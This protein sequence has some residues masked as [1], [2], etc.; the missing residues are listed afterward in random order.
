MEALL[1]A[2]A[3]LAQRDMAA[4]PALA[5][6]RSEMG[7]LHRDIHGHICEELQVRI[8]QRFWV[9]KHVCLKLL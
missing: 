5:P 1:S 6:L 8:F 4:V 9:W 7:A 2:C 3:K